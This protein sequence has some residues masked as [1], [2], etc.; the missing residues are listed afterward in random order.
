[1]T[2]KIVHEVVPN[3]EFI[4][5]SRSA[6]KAVIPSFSKCSPLRN[7]TLYDGSFTHFFALLYIPK[8]QQFCSL[9]ARLLQLSW[10]ARQ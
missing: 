5:T 8:R 9:H 2:W 1:M 4:E 6:F 3:I 10:I 7:Q